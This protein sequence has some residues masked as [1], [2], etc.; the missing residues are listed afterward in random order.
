M[1]SFFS[2]LIKEFQE[3]HREIPVILNKSKQHKYHELCLEDYFKVYGYIR[4]VGA[5][6]STQSIIL[7]FY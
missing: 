5:D 7:S 1:N 3:L 6:I 4:I 2:L